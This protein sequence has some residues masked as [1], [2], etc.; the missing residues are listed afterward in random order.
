MI[1]ILPVSCTLVGRSM[2]L[3]IN[4]NYLGKYS[5]ETFSP[6][7]TG[8]EP[9][10]NEKCIILCPKIFHGDHS[11]CQIWIH[12]NLLWCLVIHSIEA[13]LENLVLGNFAPL[14]IL[15][16]QR[17]LIL[18]TSFT[19]TASLLCSRKW[20]GRDMGRRTL[21]HNTYLQGKFHW[22]HLT[23]SVACLT[24]ASPIASPN[25]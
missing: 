22:A 17:L 6:I 18:V 4:S 23:S 24:L 16:Q 20:L 1:Y 3:G 25:E 14:E 2:K 5:H 11:I 10:K 19:E 15:C 9:E 7:L 8:T 21:E 12:W 13:M